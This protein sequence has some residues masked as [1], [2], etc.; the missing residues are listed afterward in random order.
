MLTTSPPRCC[1]QTPA[2]TSANRE[3]IRKQT[4]VREDTSR[5]LSKVNIYK[6]CRQKAAYSTELSGVITSFENSQCHLRSL[7]L[8]PRGGCC[9]VCSPASSAAASP[10]ASAPPP[11]ACIPPLSAA[12]SAARRPGAPAA[13]RRPGR[14]APGAGGGE[15]EAEGEEYATGRS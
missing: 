15:L 3:G 6:C 10:A 4:G 9:T 13:R 1:C 8:A 14:P 11:P 7:R 5:G 12:A 2:D